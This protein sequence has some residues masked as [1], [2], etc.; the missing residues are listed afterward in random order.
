MAQFVRIWK[1]EQKPEHHPAGWQQNNSAGHAVVCHDEF[2]ATT[3]LAIPD[4]RP[5]KVTFAAQI[6]KRKGKAKK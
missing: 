1:S 2:I 6:V 4:D 3:G 5:V